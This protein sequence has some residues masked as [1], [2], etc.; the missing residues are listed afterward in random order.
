MIASFLAILLSISPGWLMGFPVP[1]ARAQS[2][3]GAV[4]QVRSAVELEGAKSEIMLGD[5]IVARELSES[6]L[7]FLSEVRVADM[8]KAGE[9]RTFTASGFEQIVRPQLDEIQ[10]KTGER[11]TL[12]VP[13]RVT[14]ARKAFQMRPKDVEASIR[15]Q[16]RGLCGD[17]EFEI[18]GLNLPLIPASAASGGSWQI[19][20]RSEI[21]KGNFSVPVEVTSAEGSRRNYWISGTL[22]VRREVPVASRALQFGEKI[23]AQDFNIQ[24]RDV[25]FSTDVG[26]SAADFDSSVVARQV[27][28]G[29]IIWRNSL[30]RELALKPGDAVKV[31]AGSDSWVITIDGVAQSN[32]YIGD[33]VRVKIPRTQKLV[34]GVLKEKGVVEVQ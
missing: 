2:E 4:I 29:Q 23:Q 33:L 1:S 26:A 13:T 30:R 18:T 10:E 24:M 14:V 11:L 28:A 7:A 3:S 21:P 8:P 9:S 6:T 5:L 22:A 25:T 19:R 32:G 20:M 17:C 31:T 27:S 12:R 34:S 15:S 16:L